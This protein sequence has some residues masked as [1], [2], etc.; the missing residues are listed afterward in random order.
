MTLRRK[1]FSWIASLVAIL[2]I[3]LAILLGLFRLAA[4]QL[5]EYRADLEEKASIAVGLPVRFG[6]VDARLRLNGPELI[7]SDARVLDPDSGAVLVRA[8]RG[9]VT[10]D[11]IAL[12][13]ERKLSA[14]RVFLDRANITLELT[15]DGVMRIKGLET[16]A[17]GSGDG[18]SAAEFPV[19]L[20]ELTHTDFVIEDLKYGLGP[21]SF[22]DVEFQLQNDGQNIVINGKVELPEDLG[23]SLS[24]HAELNDITAGQDI[25][26]W[27]AHVQATQLNL[28]NLSE[29]TPERYRVI[30]EGSG[31]INLHIFVDGGQ[32]QHASVRL[33]LADA[34]IFLAPESVA[35]I[36]YEAIDGR[37][38]LDR[39]SNG[40]SATAKGFRIEQA[41][42]IWEKSDIRL[43]YLD[44]PAAESGDETGIAGHEI[45]LNASFVGIEELAV[46]AGWLPD[47]EIKDRLLA[48]RPEG[49]LRNLSLNYSDRGEAMGEYRFSTEFE[50]LAASAQG[51]LPGVRGLSGTLTADNNGGTVSLH[52][53][54]LEVVAPR[55]FRAPLLLDSAGGEVEWQRQAGSL[56][57]LARDLTFSH[58][59]MQMV[60]TA[61]IDW[62]ESGEPQIQLTTDVSDLH[63]S[64]IPG[65][66]PTGVMSENLVRWLDSALLDGYIPEAKLV[67]DGP[68][69][70]IP[71]RDGDGIFSAE[72]PLRDLKLQYGD[73]WPVVSGL[74]LQATFSGS[75]FSAYGES[76]QVL[77]TQVRAITTRI[78]DLSLPVLDMQASIG[79]R[80]EDSW[81]FVLQSPLADLLGEPVELF[82]VSGQ[83][84]IDLK[85]RL[86]LR[87][88][89]DLEV[90][91]GIEIND[92]TMDIDGLEPGFSKIN[93]SL[94]I[95]DKLIT[96]ERLDARFLE[97]PVQIKIEPQ[98]TP[99]RTL[100]V[101][102]VDGHI[103]GEDFARLGVPLASLASGTAAY[104]A[105]AIVA[106]GGGGNFLLRIESDL[107]GLIL[108]WP[109]PLKKSVASRS[110]LVY[111]ELLPERMM[112]LMIEY[113]PGIS[114]ALRLTHEPDEAWQILTGMVTTDGGATLPDEPGL[115]VRGYLPRANLGEW[116]S[117]NDSDEDEIEFE[118]QTILREID[119]SIG[120]G[121][122]VGF[123]FG[124]VGLNMLRSE[125]EWLLAV[126]GESIEG[127]M[128]I[129][130]QLTE[131][132]VTA[133][134][135]RV[136]LTEKVSAEDGG[137]SR[138][139][140]P[141]NIPGADVV[142]ADFKLTDMRLGKAI[143]SARRSI[144]GIVVDHLEFETES[145]K[146]TGNASWL[147][148]E[149]GEESQLDLVLES[150]DLTA[151]LEDLNMIRSMRGKKGNVSL[152]VYWPG[153]P[154]DD[155]LPVIS[156]NISMDFRNG[157]LR[158]LEPGAGKLLGL[159]SITALPR[160][161]ALDFSDVFAS[162]L[163][164]DRLSGDYVLRDGDAFTNNLTLDGPTAKAVLVGRSG[165][166][167]RD[168]DQT[169]VV[170]ASIGNTLPVAGALAGGPA[171]GA[172]V[173]LLSKMFQ[174]PLDDLS[175]G[176]YR[177]TGSWDDPLIEP[178]K[179]ESEVADA[180][181]S[182]SG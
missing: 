36:A 72:F 175:Q 108:D 110:L 98:L 121:R 18:L 34:R 140:D 91:L 67:I 58:Q 77:G 53:Q 162:G 169:A 50:G 107:E 182:E 149:S 20:F 92:G 40:W 25:Q 120:H 105:N 48:V 13:R 152:Q 126:T 73:D 37:F 165:L 146:G 132:I 70:K 54:G 79:G 159:L 178:V 172:A 29:L 78:D 7:F 17:A 102:S 5:P 83:N 49:R 47:M 45:D 101:I 106:T 124:A 157:E 161:L 44:L 9:G 63:V 167:T 103:D 135:Q 180:S 52:S 38:E 1:I 30:E 14:A 115:V 86:N 127:T 111:L 51:G 128:R 33:D 100:A 26:Q 137:D 150:D 55:L 3:G 95:D 122:A 133:D 174:K 27:Q 170:S 42:R 43:D 87:D 123:E 163:S 6:S 153:A 147:Y 155:F 94:R 24:L 21:W 10:F 81:Q 68:L 158:D 177:I 75:E 114:A 141:R 59:T 173:W 69:Q 11:L 82:S 148:L 176:Y 113:E 71:F 96:A 104:R 4:A 65:I 117:L 116:L 125:K 66:L 41:G 80:M 99:N 136:W 35:S 129:P 60:T 156:G 119:V 23:E 89:A 144:A 12:I 19:G 93:G 154:N 164:F 179:A 151:A 62:P 168:Y 84:E 16:P 88:V 28:S 138:R 46:L 90:G 112:D 32:L 2:V 109:E 142:V 171:V 160:R 85:L 56:R 8:G 74:N 57:V 31:D 134:M 22:R 97:Y 181:V 145:M 76:G 64:Y 139:V 131:S 130:Y 15:R 118:L 61:T 39:L 166:A 143:A